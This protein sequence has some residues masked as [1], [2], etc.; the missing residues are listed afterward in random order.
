MNEGVAA[1]FCANQFKESAL[2]S[3]IDNGKDERTVADV[4]PRVMQELLEQV[5][6]LE[7]RLEGSGKMT[8]AK[9]N[10]IVDVRTAVGGRA[11]DFD[12]SR[13]KQLSAATQKDLVKRLKSIRDELLEASVIHRRESNDF[14]YESGSRELVIWLI[15]FGVIFAATLLSLVR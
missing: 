6:K 14:M 7:R 2:S 9:L 10:G 8:K 1:G 11:V 12:A 3:V 13:W 5:K 4:D 15:V